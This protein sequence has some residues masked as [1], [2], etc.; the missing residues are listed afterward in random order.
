MHL[1]QKNTCSIYI[2]IYIYVCFSPEETY[3]RE[4]HV[5]GKLLRHQ[6]ADWAKRTAHAQSAKAV[7]S[8]AT[9]QEREGE[10]SFPH[11]PGKGL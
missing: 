2:Y 6:V 8:S 11:L 5:F 7:L 10:D 9:K 4:F 3:S 1:H